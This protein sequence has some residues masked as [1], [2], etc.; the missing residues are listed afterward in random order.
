MTHN[1]ILWFESRTGRHF[2]I[3]FYLQGG[4]S[5]LIL[6]GFGFVAGLIILIAIQL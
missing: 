4:P 3:L 6:Q 2:I 1:D 5:L